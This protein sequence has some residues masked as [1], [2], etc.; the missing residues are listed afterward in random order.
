MDVPL[1]ATHRLRNEINT[2]KPVSLEVLEQYEVPIVASLLKLYLLELPD[3][4]VSSSL[5][6][7][8]KT[9]YS[10]STTADPAAASTRVSVLQNTLS[11]LRLANIATLDAIIT[12]FARLIDLTSADETYVS[13]LAQNIAPCILRPRTETTL[14]FEEK[15]NYRFL[16]DLLAHKDAIFSELKR[17]IS[18]THSASVLRAASGTSVGRPRAVSSD[19][20]NRRANM[21]ERARAIANKSRNVSPSPVP[22]D[23]L[24]EQH[25]KRDSSRGPDTRFPVHVPGNGGSNSP[26]RESRDSQQLTVD[27]RRRESSRGPVETRFPVNATPPRPRFDPLPQNVQSQLKQSLDVPASV[28]SSPVAERVGRYQEAR[29][30]GASTVNPGPPVMNLRHN[31]EQ[32]PG[33]AEPTATGSEVGKSNSLGRSTATFGRYP[34]KPGGASAGSST[35]VSR[36]S[37]KR[38]DDNGTSGDG[39][40]FEE[41]RPVGVELVDA[42]MDD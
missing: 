33:T 32:Q 34:R 40:S 2:G 41:K 3:A 26:V 18:L 8:I 30:P 27:K 11:Q 38:K 13:S 17:T 16:R 42:P 5:Y 35:S 12:H 25:R 6:E 20:S 28:E 31:E 4:V 39:S 9:I 10:G 15:Y 19:E 21:E 29:P 22:K 14:S 1:S 23:S 37:L 7:I 36:Q 24:M